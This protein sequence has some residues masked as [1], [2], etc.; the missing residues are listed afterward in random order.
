MAY[1]LT[2]YEWNE[3][4]QWG[5]GPYWRVPTV[6]GTLSLWK[7]MEYTLASYVFDWIYYLESV[8]LA[9]SYL[10]D[11]NITYCFEWI[12][13]SMF[14]CPCGMFDFV[15]RPQLFGLWEWVEIRHSISTIER[16]P[17]EVVINPTLY[18]SN[19]CFGRDFKQTADCFTLVSIELVHLFVAYVRSLI[20]IFKVS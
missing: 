1:V 18:W 2:T 12:K 11:K 7:E 8:Y 9:Y 5:P 14:V 4:D 13:I 19:G 10:M 17:A 6:V 3:I 15:R 16:M 20:L